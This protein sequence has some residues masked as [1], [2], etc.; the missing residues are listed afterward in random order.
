MITSLIF[1]YLGA[2]AVF[3]NSGVIFV[4]LKG[5]LHYTKVH[6]RLL[7]N[8]ACSDLLLSLI[9]FP[10]FVASGFAKR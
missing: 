6:G 2:L 4:M 7:L 10:M 1:Y 8:I 5:K 9:A 3:A